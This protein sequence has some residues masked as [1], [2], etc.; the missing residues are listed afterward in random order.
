M[1][2]IS[3]IVPIY[4]TDKYLDQCLTSLI[5]QT[6]SNIEI[7]CVDDCSTDKSYNI[8]KQY[9]NYDKRIKVIKNKK[10]QGQS[11]S[12]NIA[13]KK[14]KSPYLMF[15]DSDD[16]FEPNMCEYMLGLITKNNADMAVCSV[17]VVY[18]T[19]KKM[20]GSDKIFDLPD[21]CFKP[22]DGQIKTI[23]NG[24]P[25]RIFKTN[26]IKKHNILYPAGL[27]YEDVYFNKVYMLYTNKIVTTSKKLYNYRRLSSSTTADVY[28]GKS[29]NAC[30]Y[31]EVAILY[32]KYL[33]KN[34]LY[35]AEYVDFWT[36]FFISAAQYA[37]MFTKNKTIAK[38]LDKR[39]TNF[40]SKNYTFGTIDKYTDYIMNLIL[41]G[42]FMRR[43]N[44]LFG[45]ISVYR[46]YIKI[47]YNLFKIGVFKIKHQNNKIQYYLFG[48][49]VFERKD[50][51]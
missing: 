15:C 39:L 10:N 3:I 49:K 22:N 27:K 6:L 38:Q 47:E 32:F 12:R 31:L 50:S 30:H 42:T 17:N 45:T 19:N 9:A 36:N 34:N 5:N 35:T 51:I 16:W 44:Y 2:T 20:G 48:I 4:N 8:L 41:D 25:L 33:N 13:I 43:T 23:H 18:E 14:S 28:M 24:S 46:D 21:S 29:N 40:I 11:I 37:L 7:I 26:I 1:T